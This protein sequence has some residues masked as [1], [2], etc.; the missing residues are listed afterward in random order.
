MDMRGHHLYILDGHQPVAEP[1][2]LKWAKWVEAADRKVKVTVIGDI[3]VSTVFMGL[4]HNFGYGKRLLFETMVF[5]GIY[6]SY[7]DRYA[8]WVGAEAGHERVVKMV[9]ESVKIN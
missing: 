2:V 5:G 4:D 6:D 9:L 1:N 3:K 8:T 7:I